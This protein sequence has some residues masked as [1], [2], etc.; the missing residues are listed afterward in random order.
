[1]SSS[2]I[3]GSGACGQRVCAAAEPVDNVASAK[4]AEAIRRLWRT[5][6]GF[7]EGRLQLDK[8]D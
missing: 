7:R 3:G 5:I 4:Q 2:R 8:G 1:L 6:E